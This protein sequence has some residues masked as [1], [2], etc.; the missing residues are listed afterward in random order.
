MRYLTS[1]NRKA[2]LW[3]KV[4]RCTVR[5]TSVPEAT[6]GFRKFKYP[7]EFTSSM[8]E[9]SLH[10]GTMKKSHTLLTISTVMLC[11][12]TLPP[13]QVSK[14]GG[15][16]KKRYQV[17]PRNVDRSTQ[18][19][20]PKRNPLKLR[21]LL[22]LSSRNLVMV[23]NKPLVITGY[24]WQIPN[25]KFTLKPFPHLSKWEHPILITFSYLDHFCH[26]KVL[27]YQKTVNL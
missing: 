14:L 9:K 7:H 19:A 24:S 23:W 6:W 1:V 16:V 4:E 15:P 10:V 27:R 11:F 21:K 12:N 2:R 13:L 5:K 22:R 3:L 26:L 8:K 25:D 17:L 20:L 18:R